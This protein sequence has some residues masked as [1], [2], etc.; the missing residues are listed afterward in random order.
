MDRAFEGTRVLVVD[1]SGPY[2]G[3]VGRASLFE[4][5]GNEVGRQR[6]HHK[7]DQGLRDATEFQPTL[8]DLVE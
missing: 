3:L 4:V 2:R 6:Q 7:N 8:A 5:I 1:G